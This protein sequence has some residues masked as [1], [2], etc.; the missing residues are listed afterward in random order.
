MIMVESR[1]TEPLL[2]VKSMAN[3]E[4]AYE[5]FR[6][7]AEVKDQCLKNHTAYFVTHH[8]STCIVHN[9][10]TDEDLEVTLVLTDADGADNAYIFVRINDDFQVSDYFTWKTNTYFAYEQVEIVKDVDFIK[11]KVLQCNVFVDDSFWAYFQGPLKGIKDTSLHED[12]E[13]AKS[14]PVLIAP[15]RDELVIGGQIT[16]NSQVWDIEDADI[17]SISNIG[18]YALTRGIN[19]RDAEDNDFEEYETDYHYVGEKITVATEQGYYLSSGARTKLISRAANQVTIQCLESG[20][21]VVRTLKNGGLIE[22]IYVVK[23]T[24]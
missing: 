1:K 14:V 17:Y 16:F 13:V 19:S 11:F 4:N 10:R 22:T 21:L 3:R 9:Q 2:G 20:N 5:K 24:V 7:Q 23:E 18:Y 15:R 12:Y 6:R 8:E